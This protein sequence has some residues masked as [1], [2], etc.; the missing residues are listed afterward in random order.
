[1]A[2][3]VFCSGEAKLTGEHIWSEWMGDLFPQQR[4][5]FRRQ[6]AGEPFTT[7]ESKNMDVKA[8]IVCKPCNSGW[9]SDLENQH[10]KPAMQEL[11]L[12][13]APVALAPER[14]YSITVFAFKAAVIGHY[15]QRRKSRF[16]PSSV[17]APANIR[18]FVSSLKIPLG[19]QLWIGCIASDDLR[20]GVFRLRYSKTPSGATKGFRLYVCTFG[21]G[22]FIW[23]LVASEW[24]NGRLRR[25][26]V[27]T[28][29]Q[30][31]E[32]N[33]VS[34]PVWPMP[35]SG[36][37]AGWPPFQHLRADLMDAFSDRWQRFGIAA[38]PFPS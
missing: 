17:F 33:P 8:K 20:N 13:D 4:H 9:M 23:Q 21:L 36:I 10:A 29:T 32:W 35:R 34:I 28:L 15:M 12:S 37:Y 27:P 2:F 25:A 6:F 7:W 16:W 31:R 19:V 14:I 11:I 22:R 3:C 26:S 1:M 5:I 30:A 38:F 24:T 18:S